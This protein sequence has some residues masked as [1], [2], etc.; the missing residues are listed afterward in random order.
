MKRIKIFLL[1]LI[2]V[3][4]VSCNAPDHYTGVVV[5]KVYRRDAHND[6]HIIVLISH[7]GKHA[8]FV[9]ETTYHKYNI[10]DVATVENST[11]WRY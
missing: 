2:G 3:V 9:D 5:N 7:D 11:W 8:V 1:A 4:A 6:V 10:G